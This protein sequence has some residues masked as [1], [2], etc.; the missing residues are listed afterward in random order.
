MREEQVPPTVKGTERCLPDNGN[1]ANFEPIAIVGMA[2]RLPGGVHNGRDFWEMLVNKK[3]GLCTV[4]E[5][6]YN[7]DG[8]YTKHPTPGALRQPLGYFLQDVEIKQLDTSFFS[9]PKK[10]LER[11]DPAETAARGRVGMHGER[12]RH[13]LA[14][15]RHWL[16]RRRPR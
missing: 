16:L 6:R 13:R 4:P 2:M 14:R 5:D 11:F 15:H 10:E 1:Y 12:W 3:H 8:F 7:V 9:F